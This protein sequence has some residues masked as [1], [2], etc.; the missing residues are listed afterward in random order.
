M[1][2]TIAN[3]KPDGSISEQVIKAAKES[4]A[5]VLQTSLNGA[6]QPGFDYETLDKLYEQ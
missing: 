4:S 3:M 2:I 5:V 6:V 1:N